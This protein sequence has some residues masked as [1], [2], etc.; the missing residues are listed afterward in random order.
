MHSVG[1]KHIPVM[2]TPYSPVTEVY[3]IGCL[4]CGGFDSKLVKCAMS[5]GQ[6][7]SLLRIL[8]RLQ[9]IIIIITIGI[10]VIHMMCSVHLQLK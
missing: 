10:V 9:Y 1:S 4:L 5:G 6:E 7:L 3:N 2:I 8:D